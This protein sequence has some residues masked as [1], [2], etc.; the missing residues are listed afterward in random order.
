MK[1]LAEQA[2]ARKKTEL[3]VSCMPLLLPFVRPHSHAWM[4]HP[5]SL[6]IVSSEILA[7]PLNSLNQN[8]SVLCVEEW[9]NERV[10]EG[11]KEAWE[12]FVRLR[13]TYCCW[14]C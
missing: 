11:K 9:L 10:H 8:G 1:V 5:A 12:I 3:Q 2:V 14:C 7:V 6:Q 4:C 13:I